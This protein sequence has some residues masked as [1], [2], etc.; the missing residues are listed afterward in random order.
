MRASGEETK[1]PTNFTFLKKNVFN[2]KINL[3][4]RV[5]KIIPYIIRYYHNTQS[6]S[7]YFA[8]VV[9]IISYSVVP[10]MGAR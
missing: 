2:C 4:S 7:S 10:C 6:S 3:A 8:N 1:G 9:C 5:G